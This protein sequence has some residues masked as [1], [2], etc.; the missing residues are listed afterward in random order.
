MEE[1]K[2]KKKGSI[3]KVYALTC[4]PSMAKA[5]QWLKGSIG[6][7]AYP[8]IKISFFLNVTQNKNFSQGTITNWVLYHRQGHKV[9]AAKQLGSVVWQQTVVLFVLMLKSCL[10]M[11]VYKNSRDMTDKCMGNRVD[12]FGICKLWLS[13]IKLSFQEF[14][15]VELSAM[16][17]FC[18]Q[19]N[20]LNYRALQRFQLSSLPWYHVSRLG[21][22]RH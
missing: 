3:E 10:V 12:Q 22:I 9:P 14:M 1:N 7:I 17:H 2:R 4:P 8:R 18:I 16:S 13:A 20:D 19:H 15:K 21:L 11:Q 6:I 5:F